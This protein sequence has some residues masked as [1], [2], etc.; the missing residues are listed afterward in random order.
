MNLLRIVK[1]A[2]NMFSK[3]SVNIFDGSKYR[4]KEE[5]M[6]AYNEWK[7]QKFGEV[8]VFNAN[9]KNSVPTSIDAIGTNERI[10]ENYRWEKKNQ[11]VGS[12]YENKYYPAVEKRSIDLFKEARTERDKEVEAL[13]KNGIFE[14]PNVRPTSRNKKSFYQKA[15]KAK[16]TKYFSRIWRAIF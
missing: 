3:K 16:D 5:R 7:N 6:N 9:Y 4:N 12:F 10:K 8:E 14:R 15:K 13:Y 11:E 2:T 1:K